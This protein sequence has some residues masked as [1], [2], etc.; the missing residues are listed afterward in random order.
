MKG[1][2][3]LIKVDHLESIAFLLLE[4]AFWG[5]CLVVELAHTILISNKSSVSALFI[6]MYHACIY[7]VM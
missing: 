5:A 3:P 4:P 1:M 7:S 6:K 2:I